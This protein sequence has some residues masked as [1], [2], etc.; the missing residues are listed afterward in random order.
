MLIGNTLSGQ[1]P[2]LESVAQVLVA[3]VLPLVMLH[4][5]GRIQGI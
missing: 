3:F 4:E 2:Y 5:I 1:F